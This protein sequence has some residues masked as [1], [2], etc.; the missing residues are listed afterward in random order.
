MR[1]INNISSNHYQEIL[2]IANN[3]DE[4][5]IISPF[6]M[7][8]FETILFKLKN[9]DV[10][11]IHLATTLKEN[12]VDL[13]QKA[14]ALRSFRHFCKQN[15]ISFKI[16]VDNKLHGKIYVASRNGTYTSGLLTSA[17]FTNSGLNHNHEWGIR[18]DDMRTL[19]ALVSEV[20]NVSS[21]PLSEANISS[22]IET[23]NNYSKTRP[24]TDILPLELS[25]DEFIESE[26]SHLNQS[27]D[28]EKPKNKYRQE[29][30]EKDGWISKLRK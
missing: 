13:F 29:Q 18:I 20:L 4:L 11:H 1:I 14:N 19:E 8:S 6:L 30:N 17:N 7:E 16:Y 25:V 5:Y 27:I 2:D 24:K 23:I 3:A 26:T 15:E 12:D 28:T 10:R 22:I 9:K 21:K